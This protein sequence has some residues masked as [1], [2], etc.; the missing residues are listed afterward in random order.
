MNPQTHNSFTTSS[1]H[2]NRTDADNVDFD[3]IPLP[4]ND[5]YI[6]THIIVNNIITITIFMFDGVVDTML[7]EHLAVERIDAE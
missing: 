1:V 7:F 5:K 6:I 2:V 4:Q 3:F